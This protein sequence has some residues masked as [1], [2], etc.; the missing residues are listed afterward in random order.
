MNEKQAKNQAKNKKRRKVFVG[1]LDKRVNERMLKAYFAK[2]GPVERAII[3]REHYT[4]KSRGS[5]F[6]L[7]KDVNSA[8]KVLNESSPHILE[9]KMFDCQ[10][11]LLRNEVKAKSKKSHNNL[12]YSTDNS[13]KSSTNDLTKT[14]I[15]KRRQ[16]RSSIKSLS[17]P[18]DHSEGNLSPSLGSSNNLDESMFIEEKR[19]AFVQ[20]QRRRYSYLKSH[21]KHAYK[22]M[23]DNYSQR[24]F[25]SFNSFSQIPISPSV[26]T[27]LCY[28]QPTYQP[29]EDS[30]DNLRSSESLPLDVHKNRKAGNRGVRGHCNQILEQQMPPRCDTPCNF[31]V[32]IPSAVNSKL[33][34]YRPDAVRMPHQAEYS[35]VRSRGYPDSNYVLNRGS[36]ASLYRSSRF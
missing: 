6:V 2:Y 31:N 13:K 4:D 34:L 24:S 23:Y 8:T 33:M 19:F 12:G 18:S 16:F 1:G 10:P 29:R 26:E 36:V 20:E 15:V 9:G 17:R 28:Q 21:H 22:P 35:G 5:G 7:F 25:T 11:C 27:D 32:S 14:N 3:N 30:F